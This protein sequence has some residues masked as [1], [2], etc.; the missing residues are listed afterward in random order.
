MQGTTTM[1]LVVPGFVLSGTA[2]VAQA[3]GALN[4]SYGV[5]L[6]YSPF[7]AG[8]VGVMQFVGAGNV[9]ASLT[10]NGQPRHDRFHGQLCSQ[11]RRHRHHQ[12]A[13]SVP[14]SAGS[15]IFICDDRWRA[16]NSFCCE[17][18]AMIRSTWP[19]ESAAI[20]SWVTY[21]SDGG[22][23]RKPGHLPAARTP[24]STLIALLMRRVTETDL[25][26]RR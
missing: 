12:S 26:L 20:D 13:R 16:L 17:R 22:I 24:I 2:R 21:Q 8:T 10:T 11:S 14:N 23:S 25:E 15:I 4:G 9:T 18:M 7:P 19:S 3:G 5:R 1:L 6:N